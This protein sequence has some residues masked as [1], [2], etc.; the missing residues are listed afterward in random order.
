MKRTLIADARTPTA[1]NRVPPVPLIRAVERVRAALAKLHRSSVPGN[2]ALL[3]LATG[4]WTTQVLYV[5]ATLGIA[6]RLAAEYAAGLLRGAGY[7]VELTYE[8]FVS[9]GVAT[10]WS[11]FVTGSATPR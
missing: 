5:A 10:P 9:G 8:G 3:E 1:R 2:I 6:D 11:W 4:S 7:D